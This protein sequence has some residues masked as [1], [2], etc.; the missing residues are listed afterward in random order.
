[1]AKFQVT[2]TWTASRL[3]EVEAASEDEA[4]KIIEDEA[5][6]DVEAEQ[7]GATFREIR[8]KRVCLDRYQQVLS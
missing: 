8:R 2:D 1:M 5:D 6:F 7:S 3:Y 4:M